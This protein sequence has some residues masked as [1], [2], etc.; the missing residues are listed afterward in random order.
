MAPPVVRFS[1]TRPPHFLTGPPVGRLLKRAA[2]ADMA[3]N[4][5]QTLQELIRFDTTNPPGNEAACA[6][7]ISSLLTRAGVEPTLLAKSP[8][9][10]NLIARL[11][12]QGKAPSL[13][14]YGH[15][16]VVTT[17]AQEWQHPPFEGKLVDGYVWGRGALDMK[18]G[19]VMLLEAFL[20]ARAEGFVPAGDVLLVLVSD[21]EAGGFYGARYLVEEHPDLFQGIRYAIGEFGGFSF[22]VGRQRFYPIMVA[23]KQV[24]RLQATLRGSGGHGSLSSSGGAMARLGRMLQ[25]LD[26]REMPVH[27]TPVARMMVDGLKSNLPFPTGLVLAQLLNP[28]LTQ[29]LLRLMGTKGQVFDPLFHHTV[30]ATMVQGGE[31]VNVLPSEIVV[32]MDGRLLPGFGPD[33]MLAEVQQIIGADV[34]LEISRYDPGPAEPDMGLFPLLSDIL[35][36]ADPPAVPVPMLL[37][38]ATDGRLFAKLGIQTYGFLPMP[39]PPGFNFIETI[40]GSDER[41]PVEALGFGAEAIYQLICRFVDAKR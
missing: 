35:R 29:P 6:T 36:A 28:R 9:R 39:L 22:Y 2:V 30:N 38:G 8:G 7:Y 23:E 17:A 16:D 41:L 20:R 5:T 37:P 1:S 21:E 4:L 40:H 11:P 15:L 26:R 24:C 3:L 12:G 31:K 34:D 13:M 19:V 25:D 33:D 18:G 27:V 14:L 32:D 10:P